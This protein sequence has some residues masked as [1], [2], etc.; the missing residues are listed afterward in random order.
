MV[1][2]AST[3]SPDDELG[4]LDCGFG[5][6]KGCVGGEICIWVSLLL[7]SD[8]FF[9]PSPTIALHHT[10]TGLGRSY[11]KCKFQ[12]HKHIFSLCCDF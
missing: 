1:I 9:T 7:D 8:T 2:C 10:L 3:G 11:C 4:V 5:Q 12:Q 6:K